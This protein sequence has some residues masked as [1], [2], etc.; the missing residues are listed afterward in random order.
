[1]NKH[2]STDEMRARYERA[3]DLYQERD[4]L[5]AN[6]MKAVK[7]PLKMARN[8]TPLPVW[9]GHSDSFWYERQF[10]T[11][12]EYRLIDAEKG[13]NE[14]AFDHNLFAKLLASASGETVNAEH[15]PI[16]SVK[17][18][19]GND[20]IE[21]VAFDKRWL[22]ENNTV[23]EIITAS[24]DTKK[25]VMGDL[26]A[27]SLVSP[28]GK[29]AV[30]TR[31]YNLWLKDLSSGEEWALTEDGEEF[32]DYAVGGSA[33]AFPMTYDIQARW[34]PDSRR[35]FTLQKDRRQV[36]EMPVMQYVP[37][38]GTVRP[39]VDSY[40]VAHPG[41]EHVEEYRLF[42]IEVDSGR[43][44]DVDYKRVPTTRNSA[45]FFEVDLGWWG[46]DSRL[47][48][49]IDVDRYYKYARLVEFNT[50]T[51]KTR[52][53]FE[54]TSDTRVRFMLHG[55]ALPNFL[56]LPDTNELLWY[57]ERSGWGHFYLYDLVT[58]EL[59]KTVTE[60][61][62][63]V[64]DVVRYEE[65][66]RELFI[67]TSGRNLDR[68]P[69]Y[70]DLV[71]VN[72]DTGSMATIVESDHE[73]LTITPREITGMFGG[74]GAISSNGVSPTGNFAVVT[75][76]R[77]DE[78]PV[79]YLFS[80]GGKQLLEIES[81]DIS[82]L[83]HDWQWPEPVKVKAADGE[84]DI[85]GAIY[86]PRGFSPDK[87][88]PIIDHGFN[89]PDTP[90]VPKGSFTCTSGFGFGFYEPFALAEL[91]FIVVQIDG[92][93]LPYRSREFMDETY[94]SANAS[95]NLAD[96]VAG[97]KQLAE[98]YPYMDINRVG[99]TTA[100]GGA[101]GLQ[102]LLHHPEF[103]KVGVQDTLPDSRL[104]SCTMWG[105]MFEGPLPNSYTPL[106]ELVSNMKGKLLLMHNMFDPSTPV[107][108][109][110]RV[111]HALQEAGK[112]FDLIVEPKPK[113]F[114]GLSPYQIRRAWDH[115]VRHLLGV[116]PPKEFR[117]TTDK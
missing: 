50:D 99:I 12:R 40:R 14:L 97:I 89:V 64:R 47:A 38:D 115:M 46:K 63:A 91:G 9:I 55:D 52:I 58:G 98:R 22:F 102:G 76:S 96:H 44:Q 32:Y 49:F 34:S 74:A 36:K 69:Y 23:T 113:S 57:S 81:A 7:D 95:N 29:R 86:R 21:F 48:Y 2:P 100:T 42:S 59:K 87:S 18:H 26:A 41:D 45:G 94:G 68:D 20:R 78:A 72:I 108:A 110:F 111:V 70:R 8:A 60:G 24:A 65:K 43:I 35:L 84:T 79:S 73:Y 104:W 75:R 82:G 92:R 30:F 101:G 90:F 15:L 27:S 54:E 53:L 11:G 19:E 4:R 1:M 3:Q 6:S 10:E 106:E 39:Q 77:I 114:R 66:R 80:R 112:D 62:W 109:T 25:S 85:Y 61:N 5:N 93:G 31:D 103:F 116:E 33:W 71:R 13:T 67:T 28:D 16:S 107:A 88:Y 17:I 105:D 51:G 117:L 37:R 56:P 83:P